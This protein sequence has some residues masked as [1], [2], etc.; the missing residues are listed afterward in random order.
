MLRTKPQFADW[1][2]LDEQRTRAGQVGRISILAPPGDYTVALKVGDVEQTAPIEVRKDPKSEGTLEDIAEQ[3]AMLREL[4]ADLEVVVGMVNEIEWLR[5]QVLDLKMVA[6]EAGRVEAIASAV[7]DL[8]GSLLAVE[9]PLIQLLLTGTGQDQ[10]R[11]P[12]QL[13]GRII[14]L[15]GAVASNDFPPTD[16]MRE[17][18]A[19]LREQLAAIQADYRDITDRQLP[20]ANRVL[21]AAGVPGLIRVPAP[22]ER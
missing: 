14:Y 11:W 3:T 16:Q 22:G 20:D 4:R 18:H 12:V 1:V 7:D 15:A 17:V 9:E 10:I 2:T 19:V 5:R 13:A 21:G 6:E 8:D